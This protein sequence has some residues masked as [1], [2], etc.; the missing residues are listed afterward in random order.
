MAGVY[1]K[2]ARLPDSCVDCFMRKECF[3]HREEIAFLE[4]IHGRSRDCPLMEVPDHGDLIDRGKLMARCAEEVK[5]SNNSDFMRPPV[6]ND[7]V[8]L[9]E[10]APAVIPADKEGV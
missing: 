1:I 4:F 7:A 5:P 3:G 8:Q 9:I 2:G 10:I 6:W